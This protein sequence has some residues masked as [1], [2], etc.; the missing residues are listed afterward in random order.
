[1]TAAP[2][3][4]STVRTGAQHASAEVLRVHPAAPGL[5]RSCSPGFTWGSTARPGRVTL[6]GL[7]KELEQLPGL[8]IRRSSLE[9]ISPV[10]WWS[11]WP[12]P[13]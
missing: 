5:Q 4:L 3:A 9:P 7:L 8:E 6:A 13:R 2:I 10:N 11:A 12:L 1:M